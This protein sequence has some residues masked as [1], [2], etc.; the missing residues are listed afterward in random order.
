MKLMMYNIKK[1]DVQ[2]VW[3][4]ETKKEEVKK[5]MYYALWGDHEVL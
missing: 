1:E 3:I 2:L 5:E 4:Q